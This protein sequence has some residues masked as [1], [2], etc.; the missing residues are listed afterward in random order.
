MS[1]PLDVVVQ[2]SRRSEM[3]VSGNSE[4][5]WDVKPT[6]DT[7]SSIPCCQEKLRSESNC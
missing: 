7:D 4:R 3:K 5:L 2:A 6:G 1:H